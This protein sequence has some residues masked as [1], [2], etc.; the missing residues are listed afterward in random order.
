M[1]TKVIWISFDLG[2]KGD[3]ENL[4][5]WLDRHG[6][7]ECGDNLAVLAYRFNGKD[8]LEALKKDLKRAITIRNSDRI[9]VI[10]LKEGVM[11]GKFIFG[12]RK[13]APW[14][15]YGKYLTEIDDD[16]DELIK[17]LSK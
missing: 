11:K 4:Y 8:L 6:A 2:I 9:Y 16:M 10:Y 5:A 1:T 14:E 15:R 7:R 12:K 13:V 3:Y 17:E